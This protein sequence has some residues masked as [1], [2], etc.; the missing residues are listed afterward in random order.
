LVL[1][2]PVKREWLLVKGALPIRFRELYP[3]VLEELNQKG[4]GPKN[5]FL[6]F[7]SGLIEI[8]PSKRIFAQK[9]VAGYG[10]MRFLIKE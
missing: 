8:P 5:S 1:S 6:G 3:G 10:H 4:R 9:W 7:G 2:D